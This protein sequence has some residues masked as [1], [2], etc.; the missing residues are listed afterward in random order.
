M[1][2]SLFS[3][4]LYYIATCYNLGLWF[5]LMQN[6]CFNIYIYIYIYLFLH[7]CY[8]LTLWSCSL[9]NCPNKSRPDSG[10][11]PSR[12]LVRH[13][14]EIVPTLGFHLDYPWPLVG[15][16]GPGRAQWKGTNVQNIAKIV[17]SNSNIIQVVKL[18]DPSRIFVM[19]IEGVWYKNSLLVS[20]QFKYSETDQST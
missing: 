12:A 9:P 5:G 19:E 18:H 14:G 16:R 2:A 11:D 6:I 17:D 7:L 15:Q 3:I 13:F 8:W 20:K 1:H 10:S 4:T